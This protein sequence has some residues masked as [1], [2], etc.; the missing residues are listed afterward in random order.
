MSLV[1]QLLESDEIDAKSWIM[2]RFALPR[3]HLV[4]H[5][6][7]LWEVM[8]KDA[9]ETKTVSYGWISD[10]GHKYAH[11]DD[12]R[13]NPV[14]YTCYRYW[15][16]CVGKDEIGTARHFQTAVKLCIQDWRKQQSDSV[17]RPATTESMNSDDSAKDYILGLG[18]DTSGVTPDQL[19]VFKRQAAGYIKWA[20][21]DEAA[22][23]AKLVL[24][25][26]TFHEAVQILA[27]HDDP[28][29]SFISMVSQGYF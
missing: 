21:G 9:D 26:K 20:S 23:D 6:A 1:A 13:A 24:R 15:D 19:N 4:E 28:A 11:P 16:G 10:N 25:A 22:Q 8:S 27:R 14:E 5:D 2:Q 18:L 3:Y 29:A 17:D 7:G 12:K